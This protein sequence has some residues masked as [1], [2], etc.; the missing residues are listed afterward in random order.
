M[1]QNILAILLALV[2]GGAC[3][4]AIETLGHRVYPIPASFDMTDMK[5]VAEYMK[6]APAGALVFVLLA[7]SAG[8]FAGGFTASVVAK[9]K[10]LWMAGI[11]G[12]VALMLAMLN[13]LAIPHPGWMVGLALVLPIPVALLGGQLGCIGSSSRPSSLAQ[14]ETL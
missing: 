5:Q 7:Q 14:D 9:S 1:V 11:Y 8:S 10:R 3:V 12:I 6:T 4:L 2:V 13:V